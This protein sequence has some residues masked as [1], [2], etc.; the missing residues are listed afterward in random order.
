MKNNILLLFLF[1]TVIIF[2]CSKKA[3]NKDL[4]QAV[5]PPTI[6]ISDAVCLSGAINGTMLAGK[7]YNVCGDIF[8]KAGDTLTI[9]EGV[10]L[11]FTSASVPI[12]L[13]V[14]GALF[15]LGTKEKPILITYPGVTKTDQLGAN[16]ECVNTCSCIMGYNGHLP[17]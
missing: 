2:S 14:N 16:P 3:D 1:S 5:V 10:T 13:G 17:A 6:P 15:C 4:W 7:T 9:Q 12:G 11:N 8:V